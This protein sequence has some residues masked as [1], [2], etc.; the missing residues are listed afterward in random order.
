MPPS[1]SGSSQ[2]ASPG[3]LDKLFKSKKSAASPKTTKSE[4]KV[5]KPTSAKKEK[6]ASSKVTKKEDSKIAKPPISSIPRGG[7]LSSRSRTPSRENL[8]KCRINPP[9]GVSGITKPGNRLSSDSGIHSPAESKSDTR[10]SGLVRNNSLP[11][12]RIH[13]VKDSALNRQTALRASTNSPTPVKKDAR[14]LPK[15]LLSYSKSGGDGAK[16]S[17]SQDKSKTD[18]SGGLRLKIPP[19]LPSSLPPPSSSNS[20]TQDSQSNTSSAAGKTVYNQLPGVSHYIR[21]NSTPAKVASSTTSV[22]SSTGASDKHSPYQSNDD[23]NRARKLQAQQQ[24]KQN[25]VEMVTQ[26]DTSALQKIA[27]KTEVSSNALCLHLF[28]FTFRCYCSCVGWLEC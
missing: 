24:A 6:V 28:I 17:Q 26:T 16:G 5:T 1:A 9:G 13:S 20:N 18:T 7:S 2:N 8:A 15:A 3:V 27:H 10:E 11:S 19:P 23:I 22:S 21:P 4:E 14:S 25:K 12:S